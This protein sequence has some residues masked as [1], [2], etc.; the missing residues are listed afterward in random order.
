MN[1][2]NAHAS[3]AGMRVQELCTH[4]V[5]VTAL[6]ATPFG[7]DRFLLPK[8]AVLAVLVVVGLG[9]AARNG[10][11]GWGRSFTALTALI[12]VLAASSLL[13]SDPTTA[14]LGTVSR[15]MGVASWMLL[16]GIALLGAAYREV[17]DIDR[18]LRT[19][20]MV[21]AAV[22]VV[23]I[24]QT[25]IDGPSVRP[26][27]SLGSAPATGAVLAVAV[28]VSTAAALARR[29]GQ[30]ALIGS[31]AAVQA[32]G[33]L[34]TGSRAALV[35]AFLGV[36]VVSA[37]T[38]RRLG[39][40]ARIGSLLGG[41]AVI[42]L[43]VL[44]LPSVWPNDSTSVRPAAESAGGR[45][46]LAGMG[47]AAVAD[48]PVL[49]WGADL[50]RQAMHAH[51]EEGFE[52]RY[53]DRRVEDRAHNVLL[54]VAVWGGVVAVVALLWFAA[55]V[56]TGVRRQREHWWAQV[57]GAALIAYV[58]HLL[59][60]FPS[61][62]TDA[63]MWLLIGLAVPFGV[64]RLHPPTWVPAAL[65]VGLLALTVPS[66]ATGIAAEF[67]MG[68]AVDE[69][70]GL[71]T[72]GAGD[73]FERASE[74][75][76]NAR[77]LEVRARYELRAGYADRAPEV[78]LEAL[79][80]EP[81]DPYLTELRVATSAEVALLNR[82]SVLGSEVVT[83]ARSLVA[84]A[85]WDGSRHLVLGTACLAAG[86]LECALAEHRAA[87]EIVPTR[88][89]GWSGLG[90]VQVQLGDTA[91]ARASLATAL[92]LDPDDPVALQVLTELDA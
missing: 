78:A 68:R 6:I 34:L 33:L 36:A 79:R 67:W 84:D 4:G 48:R 46:E 47:F 5:I 58:V 63:T 17:A 2:G 64:R 16:G 35:G 8:L 59:F 15:Q 30:R 53:G 38:W 11:I 20:V 71:D 60:G 89:D 29:L 69:E 25:A 22:A 12:A 81:S 18:L 39:N 62:H 40:R 91:A 26:V 42:A 83:A 10:A 77:T 24:A 32:V 56:F 14:L 55:T 51:I 43:T 1:T 23:A 86:D 80:D 45:V 92:E 31:A 54:D 19:V 88:A 65:G 74:M 66:F 76:P 73:L 87:T 61:A 57:V 7:L 37:P 90:R 28:V 50:S 72:A 27:S 52:A 75:H 3:A 21:G 41:A 85:P 70:A 82:D 44:V 13:S 49:G 9:T